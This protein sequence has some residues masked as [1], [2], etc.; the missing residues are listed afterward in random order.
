MSKLA[1]QTFQNEF[2]ATFF[3]EADK[4]ME[5]IR[6]RAFSLFEER[7]FSPGRDLD[8]WLAAE[9]EVL[10]TP[11]VEMIEREKEFRI[12]IAVPGCEA[13]DVEI[14]ALPECIVVQTQ[15]VHTRRKE[16]GTIHI[17]E[18]NQ[19][20][21]YRR[22]ELPL[23]VDLEKITATLD[24]GLLRLVVPKAAPAEEKKIHVTASGQ[25]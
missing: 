19:R 15:P 3:E 22:L 10:W 24:N 16:E 6:H 21:L 20:K 4:L 2:P 13:R 18:I 5:E 11:P 9:R 1:I 7:G 23:P 8:D 12:Q 25:A 14:T 17:S